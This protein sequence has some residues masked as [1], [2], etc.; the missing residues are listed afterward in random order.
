MD[1]H[2]KSVTDS[3]HRPTAKS[4]QGFQRVPED[5]SSINHIGQPVMHLSAPL[6]ASGEAH[7]TDDLP[8]QD[9][10]LYAGFV[11]STHAHAKISVDWSHALSMEG[12]RGYVTVDDVPGSNMTGLFSDEK[13]FADGEVTHFGQIIGMVL[14]ENQMLA[15]RAAKLVEVSYTDLP[16]IITIEVRGQ[17]S[18]ALNI[19]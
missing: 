6:Q 5:K 7:Y 4:V 1:P 9:G 17:L 12:V 11:M 2:L 8:R 10:E 14:A 15:Q 19:R 18:H 3:F 16:S 13:V